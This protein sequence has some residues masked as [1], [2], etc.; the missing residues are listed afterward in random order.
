[1]PQLAFTTGQSIDD[2]SDRFGLRKLAK[3]HRH[4][5]APTT[6]A[7]GVT[8][9]SKA[10]DFPLKSMSI[11]Q[12][13]QPAKETRFSPSPHQIRSLHRNDFII[14]A[15]RCPVKCASWRTLGKDPSG[16]DS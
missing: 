8:F 5:L 16:Q 11:Y 9:G 3:H 2:L 4:K 1:M 14:V 7:L 6:E 12:A 10:T 13:K 15:K